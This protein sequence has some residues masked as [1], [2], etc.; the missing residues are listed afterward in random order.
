MRCLRRP[1]EVFSLAHVEGMA[2]GEA[3]ASL[4]RVNL[5]RHREINYH[6]PSATGKLAY[7]RMNRDA[8]PYSYPI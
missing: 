1:V 7:N 2:R 5:G 6:V 8:H 4:S 3:F